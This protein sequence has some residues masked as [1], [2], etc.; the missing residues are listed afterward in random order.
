MISRVYSVTAVKVDGTFAADGSVPSLKVEAKGSVNSG[1]WSSPE[2]ATWM[3]ISPPTDGILDLD[4]VAHPPN[5]TDMVTMGFQ[6]IDARAVFPVPQ[7]VMGVRVHAVTN[8]LEGR[9]S[10]PLPVAPITTMASAAPVPWPFPWFRPD[11]A[12]LHGNAIRAPFETKIAFPETV[13]VNLMPPVPDK[14]TIRA[15]ATVTLTNNSAAAELLTAANPCA[16]HHWEVLDE[17]GTIVDVEKD[18]L[19]LQIFQS[20]NLEPGETI[21]S[22]YVVAVNG[23]ALQDGR[24]Y[25]L[26][27]KF[28]RFESEAFFT[29]RVVQ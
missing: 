15:T 14:V 22:D 3:Y 19:C 24:R 2:L 5:P 23:K 12:R 1:G 4:F 13:T 21:R 29:V 18:E 20:R 25:R 16:I 17:R 6:S 9:L 8:S 11:T 28:W 10:N 27:F 26:R 7:W